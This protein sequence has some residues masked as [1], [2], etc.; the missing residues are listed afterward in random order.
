MPARLD[1]LNSLSIIN[2]TYQND[3]TG[4]RYAT[5]PPPQDV[6]KNFTVLDDVTMCQTALPY[7]TQSPMY[8]GE[9]NSNRV[10]P[11]YNMAVCPSSA[12]QYINNMTT[13]ANAA[14]LTYLEDPFTQS[15]MY[16]PKQVSFADNVAKANAPIM[17]FST[18]FQNPP[19]PGGVPAMKNAVINDIAVPMDGNPGLLTQNPNLLATTPQQLT[20]QPS[21][22]AMASQPPVPEAPKETKTETYAPP[23]RT[24]LQ[25]IECSR[26][27]TSCN[28]CQNIC[29]TK[30]KKWYVIVTVLTVIILLLIF[31]IFILKRDARS[32]RMIPRF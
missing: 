21:I 13:R 7:G 27:V 17:Q 9:Y 18:L 4:L 31:Y 16:I 30:N 20:T 19:F 10:I 3:I 6:Y 32:L 14:G 12:Q 29:D 22:A 23:E 28:L 5:P 1:E 25:C 15:T 8:M 26:H 24:D 11:A 2:P